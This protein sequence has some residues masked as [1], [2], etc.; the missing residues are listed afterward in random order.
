MTDRD[1]NPAL[2]IG[3][4]VCG[5]PDNVIRR[6]EKGLVMKFFPD[7][8]IKDYSAQPE[9]P[10]IT[11]DEQTRRLTSEI[12][13]YRRFEE[14]KCPFVPKLLDVSIEQRWFA[15]SLVQGSNLLE[16]FEAG[17]C[18]FSMRQILSKIDEINLWLRVHNFGDFGNKLKDFVLAPEGK[19]YLVDFETEAGSPSDSKTTD[20]Y[21]AIIY[22]LLERILIRKSRKAKL[23]RQFLLFSL[24]V[25]LKRPVKTIRLTIRCLLHAE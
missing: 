12:A 1:N 20:I 17:K 6:P 7:R 10:E 3:G 14:L 16:L 19:L 15:V 18:R 11:R 9:H 4:S 13:A 8:V 22:D 25:F 24:N 2:S 23:T 21:E 5:E